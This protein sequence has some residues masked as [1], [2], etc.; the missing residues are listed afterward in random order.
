MVGL[1]PDRPL[2]DGP[3]SEVPAVRLDEGCAHRKERAVRLESRVRDERPAVI[4]ERRHPVADRFPGLRRGG[5]DALTKQLE[6]GPLIGGEPSAAGRD[7]RTVG[8]C[9]ESPGC[10]DAPQGTSSRTCSDDGARTRLQMSPPR[11]ATTSTASATPIVTGR[12][13]SSCGS[14]WRGPRGSAFANG[15]GTPRRGRTP[16][17]PDR[18]RGIGCVMLR[19]R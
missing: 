2:C 19:R 7:Y 10:R 17:L 18:T 9:P 16:F 14:I 3:R 5:R 15:S 13:P 6:R 1:E 8:C 12:W 4:A 11:S